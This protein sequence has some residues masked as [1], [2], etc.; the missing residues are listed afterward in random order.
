MGKAKPADGGGG[1][2]ENL[3]VLVRCRP[4]FQSEKDAGLKSAV[5]LNLAEGT[6]TVHHTLGEDDRWTFDAVINQS[7]TQKMIFDQYI[8]PLVDRVMEGYHATVFAYG[9][10]GG[11]TQNRLT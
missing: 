11:Q 3:K 2:G 4:L 6:V 8:T 1:G 5:E 9:Q 7:L 10:S